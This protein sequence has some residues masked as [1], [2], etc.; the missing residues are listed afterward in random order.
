[1]VRLPAGWG[2]QI[3]TNDAQGRE[4]VDSC[5]CRE[6]CSPLL[7][8][9]QAGP[10]CFMAWLVGAAMTLPSDTILS[11]SARGQGGRTGAAVAGRRNLPLAGCLH[12]GAPARICKAP[13]AR[14]SRPSPQPAGCGSLLA[15][16]VEVLDGEQQVGKDAAGAG[17]HELVK[18]LRVGCKGRRYRHATTA[19]PASCCLPA[20]AVLNTARNLGMV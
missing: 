10:T 9:S 19:L 14:R 20:W 11:S 12:T 5:R 13:P 18:G 8:G 15:C 3:C 2:D 16:Q 1:M 17:G 7:A 6:C 4:D